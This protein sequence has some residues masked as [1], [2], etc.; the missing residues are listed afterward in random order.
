MYGP[1]Y[2]ISGIRVSFVV[3]FFLCGS[4]IYAYEWPIPPQDQQHWITGTYGECRGDRDHFHGRIDIDDA[5]QNLDV[6]NLEYAKVVEVYST[7]GGGETVKM[8]NENEGHTFYY[9]H[10]DNFPDEFRPISGGSTIHIDAGVVIGKMNT[11]TSGCTHLHLTDGDLSKEIQY[12]PLDFISPN[13]DNVSPTIDYVKIFE[14]ESTTEITGD[15]SMG[16][17][18]DVVVKAHDGY[19]EAG[20]NNGIY[21]IDCWIEGPEYFYQSFQGYSFDSR[22]SE[23]DWNINY[24]YAKGSQTGTNIY[25][26]TNYEWGD[27]YWATD[28]LPEGTYTITVEVKDING[29]SVEKSIQRYLT[30]ETPVEPPQPWPPSQP[31]NLTANTESD[32]VHLIWSPSSNA[33][34]YYVYRSIESGFIPSPSNRIATVLYRY[35]N[36]SNITTG[37]KYYL[38]F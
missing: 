21:S 27:N 15:I 38:K 19:P 8:Y 28:G 17:C 34:G 18:V 29:N 6:I 2:I 33:A 10:V 22:A 4:S 31:T 11:Q 20:S 36:D 37:V 26:A 7:P 9:S 32:F 14:N 3:F 16:D 23:S 13:S 35:Y 30:P 24:V 1:K 25:K 5:Q 12:N